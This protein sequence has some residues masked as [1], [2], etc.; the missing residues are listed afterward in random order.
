MTPRGQA[1]AR[2]LLP[3]LNLF[4]PRPLRS[5]PPGATR[6]GPAPRYP[7]CP[8]RCPAAGRRSAGPWSAAAAGR[9]RPA[10]TARVGGGDVGAAR[11]QPHRG[12]P[13]H[14]QRGVRGAGA[15]GVAAAA[16]L[17]AHR[18]HAGIGTLDRA[19]RHRAG[20]G[21]RIGPRHVRRRCP[22]VDH[23]LADAIFEPD[24]LRRRDPADAD[25]PV[26]LGRVAH[27]V[28]DLAAGA[29]RIIP[30]S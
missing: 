16:R 8:G 7:G 15:L 11:H 3:Q 21:Q 9:P 13:G 25:G 26:V 1:G 30:A 2:K 5:P 4:G 24:P 19:Q 28:D 22:D 20:G 29:T 17:R 23:L 12:G 27:A 6:R 14:V 18:R 10:A